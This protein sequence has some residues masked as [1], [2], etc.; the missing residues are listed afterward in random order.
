LPVYQNIILLFA[1]FLPPVP[2][3]RRIVNAFLQNFIR[4]DVHF[5][6]MFLLSLAAF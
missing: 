5:S 4:N 1:V 2:N 6:K 3:N